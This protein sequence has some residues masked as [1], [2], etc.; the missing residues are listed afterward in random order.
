MS[1]LASGAILLWGNVGQCSPPHLVM[2]LT[3]EPS[4]PHLCNDN[5]F[6]NVWIQDQP[7]TLDSIQQLTKYI[8]KDFYQT[9]CDN[10]SGYDHI[11]LT[12]DSHTYFCF[13]W[14][15]WFFVSC[16]IPFGW[17]TCAYIHHTTGLVATHYLCSFKIPSS[18]YR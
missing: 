11:F 2:P 17:K 7:F 1:Q 8:E 4:K 15:G 9:V 10:K 5:R 16:S 6:L 12:P 14:A 3:V 13:Q 18:L